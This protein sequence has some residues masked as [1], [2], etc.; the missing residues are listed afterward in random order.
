MTTNFFQNIATLNLPGTWNIVIT[1]DEQGNFTVSELFNATCGDKAARLIIPVT[2]TGSAE[3][4]DA[5]FFDEITK[6]AIQSAVLQSNMEAHLKSVE[7]A[8]AASKM[9]QDK[10]AKEAKAQTANAP[11]KKNTGELTD[12]KADKKKAYETA[13]KQ[14]ADLSAACKYVEAFGIIACCYRPSRKRK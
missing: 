5:G 2:L 14:V 1:T 7:A 3:D 13:M 4:F 8:R 10:K 6:P 9:E 11:K 12:Q